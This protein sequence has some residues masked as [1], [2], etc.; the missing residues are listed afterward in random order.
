MTRRRALALTGAALA[1][2]A[3]AHGQRTLRLRLGHGLPRSHPVHPAMQFFADTLRERS[4]GAIETT[5]FPDGAIGQEVDLLSQ[6]QAGKLDFVK[7][8][9]SV[10]ESIGP[11][12]RVFSLPFIFRDK[13][14]WRTVTTNEIGSRILNSTQARGLVGLTY[15]E[16]GSRS[17]YGRKPIDHPDDLKG[18]KIRIQQSPT[19][20]R[21]MQLFGAEGVALAWE[22][23]YSAL[24]ARLVVGA[25][26]S[27][28]SLIVGRHGE[29]VT[30]YSFD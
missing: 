21:M 18:L 12:Y 14:H 6:A 29:V 26:N 2:P 4:G 28:V 5:L 22:N 20:R 24:R 9:A 17:F 13:A 11:A 23:V 1:C 7:V 27:L 30:H 19:M 10:M 25:E 16:A 15:Y 8:S 3:V